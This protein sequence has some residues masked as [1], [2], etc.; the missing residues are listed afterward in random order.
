M[1]DIFFAKVDLPH[2]KNM[3]LPV[4]QSHL[5]LFGI[6]Q[7]AV[8]YLNEAHDTVRRIE[9]EQTHDLGHIG[10]AEAMCLNYRFPAGNLPMNQCLRWELL[11]HAIGE[12]HSI[13]EQFG[14]GLI[15]KPE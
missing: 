4:T 7:S 14:E 11:L 15:D 5:E 6:R 9:H 1:R 10:R 12:L 13:K 8:H 3:T 2:G